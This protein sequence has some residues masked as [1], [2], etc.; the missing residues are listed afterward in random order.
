MELQPRLI[1]VRTPR[2]PRGVV[3][4][5]HGGAARR[6]AVAVSPTQLS[7]LRMVPIARRIARSRD[8]AVLRLLN[9]RRGWAQGDTPL[10]GARRQETG[11]RRGRPKACHSTWTQRLRAV[12]KREFHW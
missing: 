12:L 9:S 11:D 5:L 7:V 2:E 6:E 3:L 1:A 10:A 4:V 8:L